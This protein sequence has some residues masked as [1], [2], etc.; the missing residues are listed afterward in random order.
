MGFPSDF[1]DELRSRLSISEVVG[2]RVSWDEKKSNRGRGDLWACCPFHGEKSP[3]FHV[4]ESQGFYHCF[5][6]QEHGSAIDFVMKLDRLTFPEAVEM[7]AGEVGL[8]LPERAPQDAARERRRRGLREANAAAAAFFAQALRSEA[9]ARA[10]AYL[11]RRGLDAATVEAFGLGYAPPG[12]ALTRRLA[13]EGYPLELLLE[14][15]LSKRSERGGGPYDTF[16]D[17]LIFPILD[18]QGRPIAFGGRALDDKVK[19]KYLNTGA[20]ALFSKSDALYNLKAAREGLRSGAPLIVAEGYMDVIALARGG[21]PTAVAPM[22][23]ALTQAQLEL[24]WRISETPVMALDGDAAGRKAAARALDLALPR[25]G[26]GRSLAFAMLPAGQD[27]DDLLRDSGPEA[28]R[29]LV[30]EAA[31]LID[32][33]WA[34]ERGAHPLDTPE[35]RAALEARCEKLCGAIEDPVVRRHYHF[36]LKDLRFQ[37]FRELRG[38]PPRAGGAG[39]AGP[40][41]PNGARRGGGGA[42]RSAPATP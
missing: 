28:L 3:S 5:G 10:R 14:G 22:G 17:R 6:C 24:L 30:H 7:L 20:T 1:L 33:L 32:M 9:G 40:G 18:A 39:R 37:L 16:R 25:L 15:D 21:L 19:P 41:R 34:R 23:T 2:R 26:P 29:K 31:P 36:A 8:A 12:D 35:R 27:P 13:G 42:A 4:V 11:E 38:A